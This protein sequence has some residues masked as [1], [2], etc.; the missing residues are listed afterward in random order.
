MLFL[1]FTIRPGGGLAL[2]DKVLIYICGLKCK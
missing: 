1:P 2:D